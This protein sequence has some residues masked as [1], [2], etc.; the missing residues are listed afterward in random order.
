MLCYMV[1]AAV[2]TMTWTNS[3][4]QLRFEKVALEDR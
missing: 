3:L 4:Q 1:N 2:D